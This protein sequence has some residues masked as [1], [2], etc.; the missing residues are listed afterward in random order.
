M[1]NTYNLN[2]EKSSKNMKESYKLF[3]LV[4][5]VTIFLSFNVSA[6]ISNFGT[7]QDNKCIN[8]LQTCADCTFNNI[9]SIIYPDATQASVQRAMTKSGIE[10]SYSF[11]NTS[12]LGSYTVNGH[13]DPA[14]VDTAWN[15]NFQVTPSGQKGM[16]GFYILAIVLCYGLLIIG[17]WK[18]DLLFG[19]LGSMS[20]YVLGIWIFVNGVDSFR[21]YV[22]DAFAAVT[23]GVAIYGTTQFMREI[24]EV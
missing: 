5:S 19:G 2:K 4:L 18:A 17:I 23:I 15:Y 24:M 20:L 13:G 7:F 10:Y 8:L 9:S 1:I 3:F 22:T 11:C 12:Q 14:G 21:N 16:L 6:S